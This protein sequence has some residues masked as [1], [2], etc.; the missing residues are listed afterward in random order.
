MCV[1]KVIYCNSL[2][3]IVN[4]KNKLPFT[5]KGLPIY[6]TDAFDLVERQR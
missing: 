1:R 3:N 5:K 6:E 2:L 4:V